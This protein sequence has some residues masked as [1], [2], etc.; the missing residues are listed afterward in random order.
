ME[1]PSMLSL[2]R[3]CTAHSQGSGLV[4]EVHVYFRVMWKD[5]SLFGVLR[6]SLEGE[7]PACPPSFW[8]C[9]CQEHVGTSCVPSFAERGQAVLVA[10]PVGTRS[11]YTA[12]R[13]PYC[14]QDPPSFHKALK[15][16][17]QVVRPGG[18]S[19]PSFSEACVLEN[20]SH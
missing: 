20:S 1:N 17:R 14:R 19:T 7:V 11:G 15:G 8:R 4:T 9:N 12:S 5:G 3:F 16:V 6:Y 10:K 18:P 13:S 2:L